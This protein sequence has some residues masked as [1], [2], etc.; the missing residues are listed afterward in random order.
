LAE[1]QQSPEGIGGWLILW[2]VIFTCWGI[3]SV[4]H[5]IEMLFLGSQNSAQVITTIT[6][7][8]I[9]VAFLSS[10]TLIVM[11]KKI[12]KWVSV[13]AAGIW[14]ASSVITLVATVL[15]DPED[16]AFLLV[17]ILVQLVLG[18]LLALY[19]LKSKRVAATLIR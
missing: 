15:I 13:G 7:P 12:G 3:S 6:S 8:I 19:F 4:Y 11:R 16:T 9:A 17:T 10:V 14:T 18:G 5:F 2:I 1:V